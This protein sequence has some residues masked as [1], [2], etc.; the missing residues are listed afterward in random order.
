MTGA[1]KLTAKQEAF[2]KAI[3]EGKTQHE[4][5]VSVYSVKRMKP[6]AIDTEASELRANPKVARRIA[7]LAAAV[8]EEWTLKTTDLVREAARI[9]FSDVSRI[10]NADGS[11]KLPHELDPDT[12]RAVASF[13][14]D[15]VGRIKY[16][17]WDKNSAHERLFK[18]KGMFEQDN[19]Q[20]ANPLR[21]LAAAL[22]GN[23]IGADP[24][25]A[26]AGGDFVDGSADGDDDDG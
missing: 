23:V 14:I 6:A 12:R 3:V 8:D 22:T 17:F 16:K 18:F 19:D 24:A 13:E 2:C 25:A 20:K 5:Y 26:Q 7:E 21:E 10:M 15:D 1:A 4:A 11:V 9:A